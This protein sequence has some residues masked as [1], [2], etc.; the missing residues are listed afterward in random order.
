[1]PYTYQAAPG[2]GGGGAVEQ[3]WRRFLLDGADYTD[4]PHSQTGSLTEDATETSWVSNDTG[5]LSLPD[6]GKPNHGSI[7]TRPLVDANGTALDWSRPFSVD[8]MIEKTVAEPWHNAA[9][10]YFG[11]GITS[12]Q[13]GIDQTNPSFGLASSWDAPTGTNSQRTRR[14]RLNSWDNQ[15]S[16]SRD[17]DTAFTIVHGPKQWQQSGAMRLLSHRFSPTAPDGTGDPTLGSYVQ[18]STRFPA[19]GPVYIFATCGR[20]Q[21]WGTNKTCRFRLYYAVTGA[22][23]DWTP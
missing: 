2:G 16:V 15:G 8:F 7:Y 13:T 19:A 22:D 14:F 18:G 10:S 12:V 17:W 21:T 1:M 4:D 6:D 5:T 3:G 9:N 23:Q 11:G 20:T